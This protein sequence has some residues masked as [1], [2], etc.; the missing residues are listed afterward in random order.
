LNLP[1][2]PVLCSNFVRSQ[3]KH[4]KALNP[5]TPILVRE[6]PG[7]E[8]RLIATYGFGVE[9]RVVVDGMDETGVESELKKLVA[10]GQY[11]KKA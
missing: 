11:M 2:L 6:H 7:E 1:L 5:S 8:A 4:V 9:R 10:A 3:Y